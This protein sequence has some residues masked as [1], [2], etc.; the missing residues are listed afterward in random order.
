MAFQSNLKTEKNIYILKLDFGLVL[1]FMK[2]LRTSTVFDQEQDF[3][4]INFK[5]QM[6]K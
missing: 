2:S 6:S 4:R 5:W 3:S 1:W